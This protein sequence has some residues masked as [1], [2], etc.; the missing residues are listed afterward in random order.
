MR[1][2]TMQWLVGSDGSFSLCVRGAR[3]GAAIFMPTMTKHR[4]IGPRI[5][6]VEHGVFLNN[7]Q[8]IAMCWTKAHMQMPRIAGM[9]RLMHKFLYKQ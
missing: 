4:E 7:Q 6:P 2:E 8:G 5:R 3:Q 9:A 1:Q